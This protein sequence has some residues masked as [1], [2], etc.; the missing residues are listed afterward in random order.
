MA[1]EVNLATAGFVGVTNLTAGEI[2]GSIGTVAENTVYAI[3][4]NADLRVDLPFPSDNNPL[5]GNVVIFKNLTTAID[6][7]A[8]PVVF[9]TVTIGRQNGVLIDGGTNDVETNTPGQVFSF[10]YINETIGW[11]A[12]PAVL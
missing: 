10:Y 12:G 11:L 1:I 3:T 8:I 6:P 2:S 9:P 4:G 7:D 5:E